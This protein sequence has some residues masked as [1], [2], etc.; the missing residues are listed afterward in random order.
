MNIYVCDNKE[1]IKVKKSDIFINEF[2]N[3]KSCIGCFKCWINKEN[4]CVF[5]DSIRD[6]PNKILNCKN[7]I[8]ISKISYGCYSSNIK[9]V[10]E[11]I[12]S[13]VSPYF[14][15]RENEIHHIL[16]CKDVNL[17]VFIYNKVTLN[18][19]KVFESLVKR[20][21]KNFGIKSTSIIYFQDY[22]EI[23]EYIEGGSIS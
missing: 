18:S 10:L 2:D 8:L 22:K 15:I 4:K 20:N 3:I 14:T 1:T 23:K 9:K 13:F 17:Q 12:I 19:R 11:R 5:N 16:K 21:I 7:I 6:I